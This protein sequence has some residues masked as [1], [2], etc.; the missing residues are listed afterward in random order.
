MVG[1]ACRT[2]SKIWIVLKYQS[3]SLLSYKTW[4]SRTCTKFAIHRRQLRT[5]KPTVCGADYLL[6][7]ELGHST[8]MA[9]A[10]V[11]SVLYL[12]LMGSG[13]FY[14]LFLCIGVTLFPT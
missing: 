14:C 1:P 11:T 12:L 13:L 8:R 7:S 6:S 5:T 3:I 10:H 4:I 2:D 9:S